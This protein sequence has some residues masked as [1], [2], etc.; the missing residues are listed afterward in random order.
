MFQNGVD[1]SLGVGQ[2]NSPRVFF[3][4]RKHLITRERVSTK[5][6]TLAQ[7]AAD[8][9][10]GHGIAHLAGDSDAKTPGLILATHGIN[11]K[12]RAMIFPSVLLTGQK[13]TTLADAPLAGPG[14]GLFQDLGCQTFAAFA[15]TAIDN[16]AATRSGHA[17][18]KAMCAFASGDAGLIGSFHWIFLL[19]P[20]SRISAYP[21]MRH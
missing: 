20:R 18:Q 7:H 1:F 3:G 4:N 14:M 16:G 6:E 11:N 21:V 2:P 19:R 13:V 17:H 9:V 10:A 12:T 15:T 8:P 5:T